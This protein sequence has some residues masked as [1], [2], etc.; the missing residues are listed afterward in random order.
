VYSFGVFFHPH[1][2]NINNRHNDIYIYRFVQIKDCRIHRIDRVPS[3]LSSRPDWGSPTPSRRRVCVWGGGGGCHLQGFSLFHGQRFVIIFDM[4]EFKGEGGTHIHNEL[5][6]TYLEY[7]S[8]C[9]L[10]GIGNPP[11]PHSQAS[12]PTLFGSGEG[13][14]SLSGEGESQFRRGDRHCCTLDMHPNNV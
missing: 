14:H 13:T 11:P 9:L 5:A 8:V 6:H 10:V 3:F 1:Q 7:N 2:Y 4:T 12:V